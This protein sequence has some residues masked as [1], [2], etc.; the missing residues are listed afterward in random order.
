VTN[1][2][3]VLDNLQQIRFGHCSLIIPTRD[4]QFQVLF[5]LPRLKEFGRSEK[6]GFAVNELA[7][8]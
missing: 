7:M 2:V 5:R 3:G 4:I 6:I 8:V 1:D